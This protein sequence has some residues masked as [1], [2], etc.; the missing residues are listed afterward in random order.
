MTDFTQ[1]ALLNHVAQLSPDKRSQFY[2]DLYAGKHRVMNETGKTID[3]SDPN[4]KT[5]TVAPLYELEP[6]TDHMG[7][8]R[9]KLVEPA[10]P[11]VEPR[12]EVDMDRFRAQMKIAETFA[13][14]EKA[15]AIKVIYLEHM[16]I[17]V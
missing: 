2:R 13:P 4:P 12:G 17:E 7:Q 3:F 6:R 10:K 15:K 5:V 11:Q 16:G 1:N 9:F 14:E 8:K